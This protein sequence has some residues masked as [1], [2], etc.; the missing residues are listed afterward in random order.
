MI[1]QPQD[2]EESDLRQFQLNLRSQGKVR[3]KMNAVPRTQNATGAT[4]KVVT[5]KV[6]VYQNKFMHYPF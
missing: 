2:Y 6:S 4:S 5:V 3:L 1:I